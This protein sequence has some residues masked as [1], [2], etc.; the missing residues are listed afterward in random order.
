MIIIWLA[1]HKYLKHEPPKFLIMKRLFPEAKVVL[2]QIYDYS[3][4]PETIMQYI[5]ITSHRNTMN[6]STVK[7]YTSP[8]YRRSTYI[9][10]IMAI[11][12]GVSGY[13]LIYVYEKL[14]LREY[15]S[16]F[17]QNTDQQFSYTE[18]LWLISLIAFF[19]AIGAVTFI[20]LT[21]RRNLLL[22]GLVLSSV[23]MFLVSLSVYYESYLTAVY[24]FML[25]MVIFYLL[26]STTIWVY[27]TETSTDCALGL[28]TF[29]MYIGL[30]II[31]VFSRLLAKIQPIFFIALGVLGLSD[32]AFVYF[33]VLDT[34]NLNDR[35]KKLLYASINYKPR[36]YT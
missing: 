11:M 9:L 10:T 12:H 21:R 23:V 26:I 13:G 6:L 4:D 27:I 14:L 35:E 29:I 20:N 34:K 32:F 30:L 22:I 19:S 24:L 28:S 33:V 18:V 15:I 16:K 7:L 25:Y 3:E 5:S 31:T 2:Q 36:T 17:D 1:M 8:T